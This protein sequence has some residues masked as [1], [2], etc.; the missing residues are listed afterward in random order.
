MMTICTCYIFVPVLE[1][2]G[3]HSGSQ[4]GNGGGLIAVARDIR[5]NSP[6]LFLLA[7][8]LQNDFESYGTTCSAFQVVSVPFPWLLQG[9]P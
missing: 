6:F 9:V 1:Y 3:F 7:P 8:L 4:A 5:L 2:W